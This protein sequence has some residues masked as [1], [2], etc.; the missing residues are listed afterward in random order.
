[1]RYAI[2][3]VLL[4]AAVACAALGR[5]QLDRADEKRDAQARLKVKL[6]QPALEGDAGIATLMPGRR[7]RLRGTWDAQT[8]ILLS[9]RTHLGAAGVQ[10]VT[11]LVLAS[12]AKVLVERGWMAADDARIA[13]PERWVDSTAEVEGL[14]VE[15]PVS[16]RAIEWQSLASERAGTTLWSARA[17]D[18]GEASAHVPGPLSNVWVRAVAVAGDTAAARP[19]LVPTPYALPESGVRVHVAYAIQWFAFSLILAVGA[20]AMVRRREPAATA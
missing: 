14:T 9:G 15:Y 10:L 12:G 19:G 5:W 1:M 18:L 7:V 4:A 3:F 16:R 11:P 17:L 6:D 2:A 13:H 8:H 20:I